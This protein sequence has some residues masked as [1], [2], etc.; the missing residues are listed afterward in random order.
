MESD[1]CKS[2]VRNELNR[3]GIPFKTVVLG[4]VEFKD[5]LSE[6]NFLIIDAALRNAGL[7][8]MRSKKSKLLERIKDA[9]LQLINLSDEIPKPVTSDYISK[10]LHIEYSYLSILFT[11]EHGITI[12]KYIIA[13]KIERVKE[14]LLKTKLSIVDIAYKMQYSSVAHLSNQ[15]K[16]VTGFTPTVFKIQNS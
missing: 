3:L 13:G 10:K 9:I 1:R 5:K 4:E 2:F 16:K 8:L 6:E 14:L 11:E 12:E 15:F 7:E